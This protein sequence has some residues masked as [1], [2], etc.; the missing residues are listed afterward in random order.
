[1]KSRHYCGCSA[2]D[3]LQQENHAGSER[4]EMKRGVRHDG[5][6]MHEMG[7][8]SNSPMTAHSPL[9]AVEAKDS[10]VLDDK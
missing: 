5:V 2:T 3:L 9:M 6:S 8:N 10:S 7:R 4:T 1:M